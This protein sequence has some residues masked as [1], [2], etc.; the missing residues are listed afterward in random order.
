MIK[1]FLH[2]GIGRCSNITLINKIYPIIGENCNYKFYTSEKLIQNHIDKNYEK[3]KLGININDC[4]D[5]R[6]N[7]IVSDERLVGWNPFNWEKYADS[8]LKMFGRDTTILIVLRNPID[9]LNSLYKNQCLLHGNLMTADEYFLLNQDYNKNSKHTFNLELFSYKKLIKIYED[10]FRNVIIQDYKD[11]KKMKFFKDHFDLS[12][13]IQNK[14]IIEYEN[15]KPNKSYDT[16]YINNITL[17]L[18]Y[19]LKTFSHLFELNIIRR[20][21]LKYKV[22]SAQKRIKQKDLLDIE[23]MQINRMDS[24]DI[25]L[26]FYR[27]FIKIIKWSKLMFFLEKYLKNNKKFKISLSSKKNKIIQTCENEYLE[28]TSK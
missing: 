28:L 17:M 8:N 20:M 1:K 11:L 2:I 5:I 24:D 22:I 26:N 23:C 7:L 19:F 3:M 10:R 9:Y 12:D 13:D 27:S 4:L 16:V 25:K 6:E 18:Y 21:F 15:S 14:L